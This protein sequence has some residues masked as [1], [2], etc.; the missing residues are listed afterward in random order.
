MQENKR[1]IYSSKGKQEK[2]LGKIGAGKFLSR[3]QKACSV[4][5]K[6][7]T[8]ISSKFQIFVL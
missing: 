4:K 5:K 8:W 2:N 7:V 6:I 3:T 1:N